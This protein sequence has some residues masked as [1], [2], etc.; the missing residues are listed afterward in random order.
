[1]INLLGLFYLSMRLHLCDYVLFYYVRA[2]KL[3]HS[4]AVGALYSKLIEKIENVH[5]AGRLVANV[6]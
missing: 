5:T 2:C 6:K 1:M 3:C 4:Y